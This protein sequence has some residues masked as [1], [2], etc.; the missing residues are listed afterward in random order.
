M[1]ACNREVGILFEVYL[2]FFVNTYILCVLM[3]GKYVVDFGIF[4]QW[5]F[6]YCKNLS[7]QQI[8]CL[9]SM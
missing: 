6:L 7:V 8:L 4:K 3:K 2:K 9:N 5:L 1:M